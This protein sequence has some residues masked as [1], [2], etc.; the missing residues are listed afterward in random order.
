MCTIFVN[1][2]FVVGMA[3]NLFEFEFEFESIKSDIC[4]EN[5]RREVAVATRVQQAT[6]G[7]FRVYIFH[8]FL[9]HHF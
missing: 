6:V 8:S 2:Y 9:N 3:I 7:D 1:L 4:T 5:T